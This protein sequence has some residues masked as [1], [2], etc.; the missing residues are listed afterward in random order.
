MKL[1]FFSKYYVKIRIPAKLNTTSN[2]NQF[3][4][5]VNLFTVV[6]STA[7]IKICKN[8]AEKYLKT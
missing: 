6:S 1:K 2:S 4:V 8:I 5:F 3:F 7:S